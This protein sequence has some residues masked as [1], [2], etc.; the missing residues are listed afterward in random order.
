M[1]FTLT[2]ASHFLWL[3]SVLKQYFDDWLV[4]FKQRNG[5]FF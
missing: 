4:L 2:D 5:D 1:S 3:R